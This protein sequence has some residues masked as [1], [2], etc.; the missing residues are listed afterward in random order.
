MIK[1]LLLFMFKLL[2]EFIG[3]RLIVKKYLIG[4]PTYTLLNFLFVSFM[5]NFITS[6]LKFFLLL[7]LLN[8]FYHAFSITFYYLL[9]W[10]NN[11]LIIL[12]IKYLLKKCLHFF[13]MTLKFVESIIIWY[14]LFV[15]ILLKII[16]CLV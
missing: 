2:H 7:F 6:N 12:S 9:N 4:I 16:N 14:L 13:C 15:Y 11:F 10:Q 1:F 8:K 5:N 3:L